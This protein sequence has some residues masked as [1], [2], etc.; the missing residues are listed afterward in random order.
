MCYLDIT[1]EIQEVQFLKV[2]RHL[3]EEVNLTCKTKTYKSIQKNC[4]KWF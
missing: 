4:Y 2:L 1:L 3:V